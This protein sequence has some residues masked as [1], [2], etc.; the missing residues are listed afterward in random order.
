MHTL[1]GVTQP[2]SWLLFVAKI[3]NDHMVA[4]DDI[5]GFERLEIGDMPTERFS[6]SEVM[7]KVYE[8]LRDSKML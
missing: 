7:T 1:K 4:N 8:Y 6:Q 2:L 3:K 5:D